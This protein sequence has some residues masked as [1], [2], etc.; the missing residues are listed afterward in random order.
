MS[1]FEWGVVLPLSPLPRKSFVSLL[2]KRAVLLSF[3]LPLRIL[4]ALAELFQSS[5]KA[6]VQALE[7]LM[8]RWKTAKNR[9]M[10]SSS[11][12]SISA[13]Q[14]ILSDLIEKEGELALTPEKVIQATAEAY[15]IKRDD[16][17][18][19]SQ[20]REFVVPRQIAMYLMRKHLKLPF[21]KVGDIFEK[22]HSTVMSSIRQVEKLIPDPAS[23][24]GSRIASIEIRLF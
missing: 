12:M 8:L 18:G 2:E 3:P 16:L 1:R 9:S 21:M 22:N 5:P 10:G 13:M 17:V 20:N 14:D 15:G 6:C 24:A 23:D 7:A 19:R 4:A 11:G